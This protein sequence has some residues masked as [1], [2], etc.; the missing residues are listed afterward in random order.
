MK[1]AL[2]FR[3][4]PFR[5]EEEKES[6][7]ETAVALLQKGQDARE[8][9]HHVDPNAFFQIPG[10]PFAYW[11]S[12][13]VRDIFTNSETIENERVVARM[14]NPTAD[15]FRFL[16][17]WWEVAPEL[18]KAKKYVP[19]AKGGESKPFYVDINLVASW[20][21]S[22]PT[23]RGYT[24]TIHR[25]DLKPASLNYFFKPGIMWPLRAPSLCA[26]V[27]PKGT[28]FSARSQCL[29]APEDENPYYLG[30]LNSNILD[31][32]FKTTLGRFDFP[33]F[34][35]GGLRNLP[36]PKVG[37]N[38][39]RR[40]G[41]IAVEA[42]KV[43]R[44]RDTANETSHVF[45]VPAL[46]QVAGDSF[47]ARC[48]AWEAR[49]EQEDA[50]LAAIQ[51]EIDDIAFTLYGLEGDDRAALEGEKTPLVGDEELIE[52]PLPDDEDEDPAGVP[53]RTALASQLVSYAVGVAFGRFDARVA[54]GTRQV[55]SLGDPF[56][57]L[58]VY[59]PAMLTPA[60]QDEALPLTFDADGTLCDD[61]QHPDDIAARV[62]SV[63]HLLFGESA[64]AFETEALEALGCKTLREYLRR[65]GVG[66]FWQH[67]LR[68]YSKSRRKAPLFWP[69]Q[70]RKGAYTLWLYCHRLD[71]DTL[72]RAIVGYF[73][74]K[75]RHEDN[76]RLALEAEKEPLEGAARRKVEKLLEKQEALLS[77]LRDFEGKLRAA[78][79]LQL[80][81]DLND[82]VLL[83]IAPL[84]D[85]VPW[86]DAKR[87]WNEL[88]SGKYEWSQMSA[89]MKQR[90][91]I[92]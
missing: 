18:V 32:L 76:T 44:E 77:E 19:Y 51:A 39:K 48:A 2:F 80:L 63:F 67:H 79:D 59:S 29:F 57:P 13:K 68:R 5:T 71:R 64:A 62:Q 85:L 91:L 4:L 87:A 90:G 38:E 12:E 42:A 92:S 15:D 86:S 25:T 37:P 28:V 6:Q 61:E 72:N 1:D 54:L 82:G 3:L 23:Y 30:L 47:G 20:D 60:M 36:S 21:E 83:S 75:M 49:L 74:P 52:A 55:P 45:R 10:A 33:E 11:V 16:R 43:V 40:L 17:N 41:D 50:R 14:T 9:L 84:R 53:D 22:I 7:L 66:G 81:P 73:E 88:Q 65:T 35:V 27:F 26:Q 46:L 24:G 78:A 89:Q 31:F 8:V 70:S 34:I 69:L 56:E 58:P